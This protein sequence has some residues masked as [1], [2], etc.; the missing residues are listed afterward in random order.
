MSW[1]GIYGVWNDSDT[2][3][4]H[5]PETWSLDSMDMNWKS[6]N[7]FWIENDDEIINIKVTSAQSLMKD[8]LRMKGVLCTEED[9]ERLICGRKISLRVNL[10]PIHLPKKKRTI[11]NVKG[12]LLLKCQLQQYDS[13]IIPPQCD[14]DILREHYG[15][16]FRAVRR[17]STKSSG[18]SR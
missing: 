2:V 12:I 6:H 4:V 13:I 16:H 10:F 3:S 9:M 18:S 14:A 11:E 15:V 7:S 8:K 5:E 17:S 1:G